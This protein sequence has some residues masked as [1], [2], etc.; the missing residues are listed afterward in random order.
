M[1]IY[2]LSF[3]EEYLPTP[4]ILAAFSNA[5][6]ANHASSSLTEKYREVKL[7]EDKPRA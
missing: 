5:E 2:V 1:K 4:R 6:E 3:R 7:L